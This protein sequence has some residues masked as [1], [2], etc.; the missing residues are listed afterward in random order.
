ME[1]LNRLRE[2]GRRK[3]KRPGG[4]GR[5]GP[6][7]ATFTGHLSASHRLLDSEALVVN[8]VNGSEQGSLLGWIVGEVLQAS[9]DIKAGRR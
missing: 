6:G 2:E 5:D 7:W 4:G 1:D 8:F 9:R 3:R